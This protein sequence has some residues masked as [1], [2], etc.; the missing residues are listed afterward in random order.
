MT[1][2]RHTAFTESDSSLSLDKLLSLSQTQAAGSWTRFSQRAGMKDMGNE[3][4]VTG[5]EQE[6]KSLIKTPPP[7]PRSHIVRV[8]NGPT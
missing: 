5:V 2:A 4:E 6:V 8:C 1:P 3:R 7:L